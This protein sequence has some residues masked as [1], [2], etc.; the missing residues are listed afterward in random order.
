MFGNQQQTA[1][2]LGIHCNT[3]RHR[4]KRI[5]QLIGHR[6]GDAFVRLNLQNA[7]LIE[8]ILFQHHNID[9][10]LPTSEDQ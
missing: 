7:L 2:S 9:S 4:L 10:Q 5:E 3:L 1:E 6:L 8:Q